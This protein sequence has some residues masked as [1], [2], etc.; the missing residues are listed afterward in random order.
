[1]PNSTWPTIIDV[2]GKQDTI[3]KTSLKLVIER[4]HHLRLFRKSVSKSANWART[5]RWP[6]WNF[7]TFIF[8]WLLLCL[9]S[10]LLS[11]PWAIHCGSV[12]TLF[13]CLLVSF[14]VEIRQRDRNPSRLW[15][16]TIINVRHTGS[17]LF[18][19]SWLIINDEM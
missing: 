5:K 18:I 10:P 1:M 4:C 13:F 16:R 3:C 6:R 19:D 9:L 8:R 12:V 17:V 7:L 2:Y 15:P 11:M 14:P